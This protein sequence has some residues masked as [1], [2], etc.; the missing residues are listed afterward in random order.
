M[1]HGLSFGARQSQG[2][3][4]ILPA[5][6]TGAAKSQS[7]AAIKWSAGP[8]CSDVWPGVRSGEPWLGGGRGKSKGSSAKCG[9]PNV[10]LELGDGQGPRVAREN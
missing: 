10:R 5:Q 4:A 9:R 2:E 1:E 3:S 6:A 8:R 7:H